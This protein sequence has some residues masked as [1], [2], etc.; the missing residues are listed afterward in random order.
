MPTGAFCRPADA[1]LYVG[2]TRA[3]GCCDVNASAI[4]V[5][6]PLSM[7]FSDREQAR[8]KGALVAVILD[9]ARPVSIRLHRLNIIHPSPVGKHSMY[10]LRSGVRPADETHLRPTSDAVLAGLYYAP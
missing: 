7:A 2:L 3:S 5:K 9:H 1:A 6:I 10:P 8:V 4:V